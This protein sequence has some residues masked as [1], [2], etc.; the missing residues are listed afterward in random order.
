MTMHRRPL[1]RGRSMAAL[2]GVLMV[3]GSVLQWWQVGGTP[4]L[5][6]ESGNGL[7][8]S[9]ILV[10]L[11][12]IAT[13]VLVVL[14]YAA[15]DRPVGLDRWLTF[16]ILAAAGWIGFAWRVVELLLVGAFQFNAPAQVLTNGPGLWISAIGLALLARA[17]YVMTRESAYR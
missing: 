1:G 8:G 5:T 7:A 9:G 3:V 4:G 11:V 16:A 10:F 12:G 15:G 17:A 2:G 6:A 13:L 14:P